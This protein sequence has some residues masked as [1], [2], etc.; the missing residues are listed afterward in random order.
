[1][2][3]EP[4]GSGKPG[5]PNAITGGGDKRPITGDL[6]PVVTGDLPRMGSSDL[7]RIGSGD[8]PKPRK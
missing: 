4:L 7:P 6:K 2:T 8:L 5:I 1:M 3:R